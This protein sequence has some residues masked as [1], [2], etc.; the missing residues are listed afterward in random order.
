MK[1]YWFFCPLN[2]PAF[3]M[4]TVLEFLTISLLIF[5]PLWMGCFEFC[6]I[7]FIPLDKQ[8]NEVRESV[9]VKPERDET[10]V[11]LSVLFV[12]MYACPRGS[13]WRRG[14]QWPIQVVYKS[15]GPNIGSMFYWS[16][17]RVHFVAKYYGTL[18]PT[19]QHN[20]S[21]NVMCILS[22]TLIMSSSHNVS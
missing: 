18:E 3:F 12:Y 7:S 4:S 19:F 22:C 8:H 6:L 11:V 21:M 17:S 16:V 10:V 5:D 20:I 15:V 13:T 9:Q 2:F 14:R 1:F